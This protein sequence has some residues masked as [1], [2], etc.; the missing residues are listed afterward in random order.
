MK[1]YI[2]TFICVIASTA[3]SLAQVSVKAHLDSAKILVGSQA[4]LTVTVENAG[5][6]A[7]VE[8]PKFNDQQE[9]TEGIEVV[10]TEGDSLGDNLTRTYNLT[11]WD[12]G[13]Y[14]VPKLSVKVNGKVYSTNS[15]PLE[16]NTIKVDT[17]KTDSIRPMHETVGL[18][19]E[20]SEWSP[21]FWLSMLVLVLL[22]VV[23]YLRSRLRSGKPIISRVKFVRKLQ[24]HEK[25]LQK[26]EK[27][28]AEHLG[29]STEQQKEYYTELTDTLR[30]YLEDRFGIKAKEMTSSE[31][32]YRLEKEKQE[33]S[34]MVDELREVFQTADLVKFAKY[35]VQNNINDA[36][37]DSVVQF[38]DSTKQE[39]APTVEKVGSKLSEKDRTKIRKRK[40]VRATILLLLIAVGAIVAYIIWRLIELLS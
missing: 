9:M 19:Y 33:N 4:H 16:V 31:I 32:I 5:K 36:Y 40:G 11:A 37:L 22:V 38:I 12:E 6:D 8:F 7:S 2:I 27:I 21:L 34:T 18:Q 13:K 28:K 25:A 29:E 10:S 39:N 23:Y 15:I 17:T 3:I 35:S 14:N 20:W 30:Q 26:I 1:R 24:P